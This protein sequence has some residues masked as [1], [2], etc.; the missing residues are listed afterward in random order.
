MAELA[1]ALGE[2]APSAAEHAARVEQI[3]TGGEYPGWLEYMV[4]QRELLERYMVRFGGD[5]RAGHVVDVINNHHQ[6]ALT[7]PDEAGVGDAER[8]RVAEL[9]RE[10]HGPDAR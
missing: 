9:M 2:P 7:V 10:V 1:N 4:E 5:E 8:A 6:L 3:V